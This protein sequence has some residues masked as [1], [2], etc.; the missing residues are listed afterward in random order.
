[1]H[2]IVIAQR[3]V[4]AITPADATKAITVKPPNYGLLPSGNSFIR[5]KFPCINLIPCHLIVNNVSK[6]RKFP[7]LEHGNLL[8]VKWREIVPDMRTFPRFSTVFENR[9]CACDRLERQKLRKRVTW[10]ISRST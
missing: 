10:I 3:V 4:T 1:M 8:N 7:Y 5:N 9:E 2:S 6:Q